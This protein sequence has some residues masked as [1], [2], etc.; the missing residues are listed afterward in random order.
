M[1]GPDLFAAKLRRLELTAGQAPARGQRGRAYDYNIKPARDRERLEV[2][3]AEKL[4]ERFVA[5]WNPRSQDAH[6]RRKRRSDDR[7]CAVGFPPPT[8]LFATRSP[9]R[10]TSVDRVD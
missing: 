5:G 6:E 8:P 9:M 4:Y 3:K 7:S 2:E 10:F 1:G